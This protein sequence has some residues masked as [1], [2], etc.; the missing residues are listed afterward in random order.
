MNAINTNLQS[1]Q[2]NQKGGAHQKAYSMEDVLRVIPTVKHFL[3]RAQLAVL[4]DAWRG[5]EREWFKAKLIELFQTITTMPQTYQQDGKG[6]DAVAYLHYFAR[7]CDWYITERDMDLH[8][9]RQAFGL[10]CIWEQELGYVSISEIVAAG[11]ELD[12]YFEP[13]TLREIKRRRETDRA[14]NDFNSTAA[15]CH[16]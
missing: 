3:P 13:A 6:N 8:D 16:Y 1:G 5:E 15:T 14:L 10:C 2:Q 11:A 7:D 4:G 12:L 9:Q